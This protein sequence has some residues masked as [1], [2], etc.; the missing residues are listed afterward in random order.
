[1][2]RIQTEREGMRQ[3]QTERRP[4]EQTKMDGMDGETHISSKKPVF[5]FFFFY[6]FSLMAVR[7]LKRKHKEKRCHANGVGGSLEEAM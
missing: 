2:R 4:E 7:D 1:M 3:R 5:I 6:N